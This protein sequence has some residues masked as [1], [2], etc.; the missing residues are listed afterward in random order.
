MKTIGIMGGMGPMAAVDLMKKIILATKA[1]DD[2]EHIHTVTDNNTNI[3]DRTAC[4]M[5]K[6]ESPVP[7]MRKSADLLAAAGA[8]FIIIGC[9]TAHYFLPELQ[10]YLKI[11][12]ISIIEE[13]AKFCAEEGYKKVGLL[14][15]AGTCKTGM[16]Q[17]ALKSSGV[18]VVLPNK[19]QEEAIHDMIYSG[20]K[21]ND[22]DYDAS[23]VQEAL[24]E[25]AQDGVEAFILG[26]TETPV[27]VEMYHLKGNFIDATQV[28]AEAAVK[29][30]G[31]EVIRHLPHRA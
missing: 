5:G 12:V 26:C 14:A 30:A 10:P 28:L 3:P 25:M 2:Q 7:E 16:Y 9:N 21:A 18:E 24:D 8:D 15:T 22:F 29:A 11:P 27:G 13:A 6:G 4:I 19:D 20:V 31:A 17:D 23:R 1:H